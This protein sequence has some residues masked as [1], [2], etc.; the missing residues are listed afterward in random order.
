MRNA[1]VLIVAVALALTLALPGAS[2]GSVDPVIAASTTVSFQQGVGGYAGNSNAFIDWWQ[3]TTNNGSPIGAITVRTA[4]VHGLMQ[5]DLSSFAT[6][7]Y[8]SSAVLR[9]Y[10]TSSSNP[11]A[12]T[13]KVYKLLR[14]WDVQEVT[15]RQASLS[16]EWGKVGANDNFTDRTRTGVVSTTVATTNAFYDLDI[17]SFARE[18]VHDPSAN[19]GVLLVAEG[20]ASVSYGFAADTYPVVDKRP[21]L[22]ITYS[23]SPGNDFPPSVKITNPTNEA[24]IRDTIQL[25]AQASDDKGIARVDYFA[26]KSVIGSSATPP[27]QVS[28]DTSALSLG[29]HVLVARAYDT[30]GQ[31]CDQQ[32]LVYVYRM[33]AGI[34]VIGHLSDT[35]IGTSAPYEPPDKSSWTQRFRAWEWTIGYSVTKSSLHPAFKSPVSWS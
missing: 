19:I 14:P 13:L 3:S 35:H 6:N 9:L 22:S 32:M 1:A 31:T 11:S 24:F 20:S 29:R 21:K 23:I 4:T 33:D 25:A 17:T 10:A 7:A 2:V 15:W 28:W 8:V 30:I 16:D 5:F 12:I 18:W 26:D 34:L 27:Y